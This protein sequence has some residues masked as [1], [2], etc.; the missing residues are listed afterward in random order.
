MAIFKRTVKGK[1][2]ETF[3]F[4]V[5][6]QGKQ[7]LRNCF[8]TDKAKAIQVEN[9]WKRKLREG[10]AA[11]F[12]AALDGQR[13]R[14]MCC[15][16]GAIVKA[17][18]DDAVRIVKD[19]KG[20]RRVAAE[21]RRVVAYARN[22][23]TLNEGGVRGVK[24]GDRI[25]DKA[26]IDALPASI[27]T[28]GLVREYFKARQDGAL[29]VSEAQPGNTSI[30][31]T[32]RQARVAF[33]RKALAYKYDGLTLP[34]LSSFMREPMLPQED[35][36]PAPVRAAEFDAMLAAAAAAPAELALVNM[37]LRQTGLRSGSVEALRADWLEKLKDGWWMHVRVRKGRTALYSVPISR[38]LA[39]R[40]LRR[41][42][43]PAVVLPDGTPG[44][45]RELVHKLHNEWLK[46]HIGGAG[47][48]VQ[49]NHRLR[50][51]VA[52]ALLSWLGMDAAKLALGHADEKTTQKH[53]ARLRMDVSEAMKQELAAWR[54][55]SRSH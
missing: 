25:P 24:L 3:Y 52:T 15:T 13:A 49:G 46:G 28:G 27:L 19:D 21:L 10:R 2:S 34:D 33:S 29:D 6:F 5:H 54:R 17:W 35:S 22:L 23:W 50:D 1:L 40:I 18:E 51:T 39:A 55:I 30:N 47:E 20:H 8:T 43:K 7:Y 4:K 37:I 44:Q 48:R 41:R 53:Y 12:L 45:R 14:R 16:I 9:A 26:R 42:R 36:E 38:E 31:S 32:L 11:E